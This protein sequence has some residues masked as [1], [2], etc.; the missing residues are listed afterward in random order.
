MQHAELAALLVGA[1]DAEVDALL[2]SHSALA[3]VKLAYIL[4]D[5]C[6]DGWSSNPARALR[7]AAALESLSNLTRNSEIAALSA[8]TAGLE[9]L[10]Q[11]QMGKAI[12]N[13]ES[14]RKQFL[15]ID[16]PHAAAATEVSKVI[17][18]ALL[19][20]YDQA[21]SSGLRARAVFLAHGDLLAAG[22]IEHN[23]GN[24]C[25]R[26]DRYHEAEKFH[27]SARER[28]TTLNDH[29]QLS[30]INN[31]LANTHA[32]LHKFKSAEDLYEQAVEQA[33]AAGLPVTL[34]EIEGNIGNFALLRG[35]YDRALDYLER[36]RRRYAS[37]G[38]PHQS[39]MAEQEIADAYL[40][41]NLAPEAAKIYA[42]VTQTFQDLGL[43]A[44]EARG[45]AFHGRALILLGEP[46]E[47]LELL[48]HARALYAEEGNAV[49]EAMVLL[50][51]AQLHYGQQ[52]Y[53]LAEEMA[54]AA[55]PV[56]LQSGSWQRLLLTHWLQGEIQHALGRTDQ[57]KL[58]IEKTLREAVSNWQ[59]Q[60]VQRCQTTLG[61]MAASGGDFEAAEYHFRRAIA[62]T[63]EMRAPLPGEEFRT[64]FFS[65]KLMPYVE[66]ARLCLAGGPA[67]VAEALSVVESARSRALSERMGGGLN[68]LT[69]ARDEFEA[70]LL[71]QTEV[72]SE[73]L[74]YIYNQLD[75]P[76]QGDATRK[77]RDLSELQR[78]LRDR[79]SKMLE[80]TRQLQH[81]GQQDFGQVK[82]FNLA[83]L[84]KQLGADTALVEYTSFGDELLAFVVTNEH[85]EVVRNLGAVT[86]IAAEIKQFRFQ[87]DTLRYGSDAV[88]KHLPTLTA[89]VRKHLTSLYD[90]L[91]RD[92][93]PSIGDRLRLVV[94]PDRDL[95]YLPFH[96][97]HN[98]HNYL[99]ERK[100]VSY[101]P[102]AL[103]LQQCLDWSNRS[104]QPADRRFE[105]ALMLGVADERIPRVRDEISAISQLF[106][107]ARTFLDE[108]AT[109]EAL[110]E[111]LAGVDVL[112]LACH[113]QFRADNP[114]FSSLRLG[115]GW[116]T[117]RDAYGLKLEC[118][119]VTLS[120]CETGVNAVAPGD[121]LIGLARGF[122]SAGSPSVLLSLWTVDDDAT[123]DL[124]THFYRELGITKSPSSA[125][126]AAQLK[127][128]NETPHPFFWSPFVLVGRW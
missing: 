72:L 79:E 46:G 63:E 4:K 54:A 94:V 21:I 29:R 92:I 106:S 73:E 52:D 89:R 62:L 124:M 22:K 78:A 70:D 5:I 33:E 45:L 66:L 84:Q 38:M 47:A 99:I 26:R 90:Q 88:R 44:E 93:E 13:L 80:I 126:R 41:L 17:G 61:R 20:R 57:A 77:E 60:V 40:E 24:L 128:L 16:K 42:R 49:G 37:L 127:L 58:I 53:E 56:L 15:V 118:N 69:E 68:P 96:A 36:S 50:A 102:S 103:V 23:L 51:Q 86:A 125:L 83:R 85:V 48:E 12:E 122:F 121:E 107:S 30:T 76:L 82:S 9:A 101:A 112:H 65:N 64:S 7:A 111:N 27:S 113:A 14:A 28:F 100:E 35:K 31:C 67:R 6:L 115:D 25:F 98:G 123:A 87:I 114:L 117:V 81:R 43:R 1:G 119:L 109:I 39:A 32:L 2:G 18:L 55:E 19:G 71:R 104:D 3:D 8:W 59:P 97:L 108:K 116:L 10:I 75:R 110:R 91:M 120:G 74:N 11:G 95:H 34:A 105:T